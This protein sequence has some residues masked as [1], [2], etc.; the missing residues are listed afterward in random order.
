MAYKI[1]L[2]RR[3]I[4]YLKKTKNRGLKQEFLDNIYDK[5][6]KDPYAGSHKHGDLKDYYAYD[7]RFDKVSYRIAY[8]IDDEGNV[9]I[10]V[11]AGTREQFYDILKRLI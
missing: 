3:V 9:V 8:T 2:E 6:A 7:F 10:V 4:K 1:I 5:I 11:L